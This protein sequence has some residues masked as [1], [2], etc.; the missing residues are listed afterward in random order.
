[1]RK[2]I[3]SEGGGYELVAALCVLWLAV[4]FAWSSL[5]QGEHTA[6]VILA[7][8]GLIPLLLSLKGFIY[9]A[10]LKKGQ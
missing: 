5:R 4:M 7:L 3:Y 6:A 9:K 8:S 10:P 2:H 1:M